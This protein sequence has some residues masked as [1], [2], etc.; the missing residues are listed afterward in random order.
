MF[1]KFGNKIKVGMCVELKYGDNTG[2]NVVI[3]K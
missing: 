2:L 1:D 3:C